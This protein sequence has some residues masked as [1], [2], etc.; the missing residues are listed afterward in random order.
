MNRREFL[1]RA[2]P[3]ATMPF[4]LGGYAVHAYGRTPLLETLLS[5]TTTDRVLVLVQ[6]NGGN[7]GLNTVVPLDQYSQLSAARSNILIDQAKVLKLTDATG[8]HPAMTG[9]QSLFKDGHLTVVQGVSYPN[10]NFSHFRATDIWLTAADYDQVLT[11]GWLGRYLDR[12]FPDYPAGYPSA[13]MPDPLGIQIG[14]VVTTGFDG[15]ANSMG[16]AI[17]DPSQTYI[18]PGGSD[19]S[20]STPAGHELTFIRTVAQQAQSYTTV[21]KAAASKASNKSV[22]YPTKGQ[23]SLADQLRIVAQL[24][25]GGL[26]TRI[27]VVNLGGFDT[28][29]AQVD[30]TDNTIGVQ[31]TLLGRLSLA[32][33]AFLDDLQLLGIQDRVIGMTFSE[34]GRRIKSNA[35]Q[36]TDHGTAAP[37]FVFGTRVSGGLVGTNPVLPS[38]AGVNDNLAMQY[39]FRSVYATILQ[40]WFGA[41]VTELNA[42]LLKSFQNLP[43]ITPSAVLSAGQGRDVP[44][45]FGLEQN[46]PNPFNPT[47][48]I[49]YELASPSDV[50]LVV[51]DALGREVAE[52]VSGAQVGGRYAVFWDGTR[53]ASGVYFYRLEARSGDG[54][55]SFV[56]TKKMTLIK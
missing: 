42:V 24:I 56:E 44:R 3:A 45:T 33:E 8:L 36:G 12:E 16:L 47:T 11:S 4:L 51:Y 10:P 5:A 2:L 50:R 9:L 28:H 55:G 17:S 41:S 18:L 35:S 52:L 22:L 54:A 25:A 31:A 37:L 30:K 13:A 34:F 32:L 15:P 39:D 20:P 26:K 27:Y 23:N 43:L 48:T 21:V 7:D 6:L 1:Q 14:S 40:D 46:Y 49:A 53:A 38:S 19:T 29:S